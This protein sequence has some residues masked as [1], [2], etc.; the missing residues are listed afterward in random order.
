MLITLEYNKRNFS[1]FQLFDKFLCVSN[2]PFKMEFYYIEELCEY[3]RKW[4]LV[5]I[6]RLLDE[7]KEP[8]KRRVNKAMVSICYRLWFLFSDLFVLRLVLLV[9]RSCT[10]L[11][12]KSLFKK[13]RRFNECIEIKLFFVNC[14]QGLISNKKNYK[15]CNCKSESIY[16]LTFFA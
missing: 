15:D 4:E 12:T 5:S 3:S 10:C 1:H 6:C 7:L 14:F 9:S 16:V 8:D 11:F 13:I 2:C